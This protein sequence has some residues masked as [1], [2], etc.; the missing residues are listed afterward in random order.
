MKGVPPL[1]E[2]SEKRG[3]QGVSQS[4]GVSPKR[5]EPEE[6]YF[7]TTKKPWTDENI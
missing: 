6:S 3:G 7:N 4:K 1:F 2:R 5:G